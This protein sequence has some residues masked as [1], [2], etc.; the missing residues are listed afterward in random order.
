MRGALFALDRQLDGQF[1]FGFEHED[2]CVGQR[3]HADREPARERA[4]FNAPAL[5]CLA[6]SSAGELF[7]FVSVGYAS[8]GGVD[9]DSMLFLERPAA[10]LLRGKI[11]FH[12]HIERRQEVA[13]VH[14]RALG[15]IVGADAVAEPET[16]HVH[17]E[18][19]LL[20]GVS[21]P[22]RAPRRGRSRACTDRAG[23][24]QAEQSKGGSQPLGGRG[25]RLCLPPLPDASGGPPAVRPGC[26]TRRRRFRCTG[27]SPAPA[28]RPRTLR[29][30]AR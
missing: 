6:H 19:E 7:R 25:H 11:D 5:G 2:R 13:E 21:R 24:R 14:A 16:A 12:R 20:L 15:R 1:G 8:R 10:R 29:S 27:P 28:D 23:K 3:L 9:L 17:V 4:R 22:I 30:P 26:A 18:E